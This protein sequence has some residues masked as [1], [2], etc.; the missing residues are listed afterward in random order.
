MNR[1]SAM[2]FFAARRCAASAASLKTRREPPTGACGSSSAATT[3]RLPPARRALPRLHGCNA[4]YAVRPGARDH[5]GDA[6]S[7]AVA[8]DVEIGSPRPRVRLRRRWRRQRNPRRDTD[9]SY[10]PRGRGLRGLEPRRPRMRHRRRR[11]ASALA[12]QRSRYY[13]TSRVKA[14]I[15]RRHYSH[16]LGC[17]ACRAAS[18]LRALLPLPDSYA[19]PSC[20]RMARRLG[21]RPSKHGRGGRR[22]E[23]SRCIVWTR[24]LRAIH[25]CAMQN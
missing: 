1:A 18:G 2:T 15:V 14:A 10:G 6:A 25:A 7:Q 19:W 8:R 17:I 23:C 16:R 22:S 5:Q 4:S 9:R 13:L 20:A 11:R 24:A 21:R 3:E 12:V